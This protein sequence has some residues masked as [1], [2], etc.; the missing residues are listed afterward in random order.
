MNSADALFSLYKAEKGLTKLTAESQEAEAIQAASLESSSAVMVEDA[1]KYS[2]SEFI[3][4]KMRAN[5]GDA[6][7][8]RWI[9]RNVAAYRAALESGNVR[10]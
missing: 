3:D 6:E 1:P 9:N 10:D 8:E 7:A 4:T 5:Q 2:R